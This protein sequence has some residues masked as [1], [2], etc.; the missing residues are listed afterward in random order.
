MLL[1]VVLDDF[2]N[3]YFFGTGTVTRIPSLHGSLIDSNP[4]LQAALCSRSTGVNNTLRDRAD[5]GLGSLFFQMPS[6][7]VRSVLLVVVVVVV[8]VAFFSPLPTSL[9][10]PAALYARFYGSRLFCCYF[11]LEK[12]ES[13]EQERNEHPIEFLSRGICLP[14]WSFFLR[15]NL[16]ARRLENGKNEFLTIGT[17]KKIM[18]KLSLLHTLYNAVGFSFYKCW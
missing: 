16:R 5:Q 3:V 8:V 14:G 6:R 11:L 2:F 17:T 7:F 10:H 9:S 13:C 1:R 12:T 4:R 15:I 18:Q